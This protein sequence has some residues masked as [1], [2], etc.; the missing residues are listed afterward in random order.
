[1]YNTDI[2]NVIQVGILIIV[3]LI[4]IS[5]ITF[6]LAVFSR[7]DIFMRSPVNLFPILSAV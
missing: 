3:I 1:V 7:K 6:V 4:I 2:T 5:I